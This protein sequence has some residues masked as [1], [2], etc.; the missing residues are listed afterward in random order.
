MSDK[1]TRQMLT[2]IRKKMDELNKIELPTDEMVVE[3]KNVYDT[4]SII[5]E[6]KE[7]SLPLEVSITRVVKYTTYSV[8]FSTLKNG[9][10]LIFKTDKDIKEGNNYEIKKS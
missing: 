1:Y 5:L 3:H 6:N 4:H 7:N 8:A 10:M 2:E 9:E